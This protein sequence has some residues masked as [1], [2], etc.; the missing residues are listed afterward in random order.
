MAGELRSL[1][2]DP[3]SDL[4][5]PM[6]GWPG[7]LSWWPNPLCMADWRPDGAYVHEADRVF[8]AQLEAEAR[9]HGWRLP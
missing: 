5:G 9:A 1:S 7:P 4:R 8:F 3:H 6:L 2:D